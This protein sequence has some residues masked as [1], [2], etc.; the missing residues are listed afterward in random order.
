MGMSFIGA[1]A[2]GFFTKKY[3]SLILSLALGLGVAAFS[4]WLF[5]VLPETRK[6]GLGI[7]ALIP[8]MAVLFGTFNITAALLGGLIGTLVG[9]RRAQSQA[10]RPGRP[11]TSSGNSVH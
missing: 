4:F 10:K 6:V 3:W 2:I 11:S 7:I 1:F 9:K 5:L 8:V